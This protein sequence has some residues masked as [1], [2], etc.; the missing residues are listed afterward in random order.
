M[1]EY[2]GD[3]NELMDLHFC[4]GCGSPVRSGETYCSSAC[5]QGIDDADA[6]VGIDGPSG[7]RRRPPGV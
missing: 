1:P 6:E 3:Y 4:A 7:P 5:K 2:I